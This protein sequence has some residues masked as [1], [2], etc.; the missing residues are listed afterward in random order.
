MWLKMATT[1]S[2]SEET[3][4]KLKDLKESPKDSYED[5][6]ERLLKKGE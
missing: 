2:I 1:I 3:W 4:K 6:I 5:V